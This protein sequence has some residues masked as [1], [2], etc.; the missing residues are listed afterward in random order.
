M[1]RLTKYARNNLQQNGRRRHSAVILFDI[2]A[3]FDSVW[4][5]GLIYK[6][7]ELRIPQYLMY[8]LISF[9][10]NRTA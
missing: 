9:L 5:D 1:I 7:N 6:L 4:H 10:Q 8:Y 3:A 2:K